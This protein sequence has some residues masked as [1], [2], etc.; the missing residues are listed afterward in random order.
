MAFSEPRFVEEVINGLSLEMRYPPCMRNEEMNQM[1]Y[2][3]RQLAARISCSTP[4]DARSFSSIPDEPLGEPI[5]LE[6]HRALLDA[7]LARK[8]EIESPR[9]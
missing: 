1:R 7:A 9:R 4:Q 2:T 3:K 8:K 5:S 6:R